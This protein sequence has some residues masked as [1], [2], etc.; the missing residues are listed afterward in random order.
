MFDLSKLSPAWD[1][2]LKI[3][4]QRQVLNQ[5]DSLIIRTFTLTNNRDETDE[6]RIKENN[7]RMFDRLIDYDSSGTKHAEKL[8]DFQSLLEQTQDRLT[9][10][11]SE[12]YQYNTSIK[13]GQDFLLNHVSSKVPLVVLY[14]DLVGSTDMSM[15]L[16]PDK[17][18]TIIRAFSHEMSSVVKNYNGYVLKYVGDAIIAFFDAGYNKYLVCDNALD[19]AESMINVLTNGLNPIL[20]KDNLPQLRIKIGITEGETVVV[21]YGYDK[22]SQLDLLGYS[23]NVAAKITSLTPPNKIS[24][25]ENV[26]KLYIPNY[27]QNFMN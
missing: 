1:I 24:I 17:L 22:S 19:C 3:V 12:R 18:V 10:A 27:N 7:R 4:A 20:S 14:A 11:L 21:Q 9:D 6:K 2:L 25:G 8:S 13:R 23:L 26:F 16:P 5:C 15:T